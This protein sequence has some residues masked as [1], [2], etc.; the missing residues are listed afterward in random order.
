[1]KNDD[2]RQKIEQGGR[3]LVESK[4]DWQAV[5]SKLCKVFEAAVRN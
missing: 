5:G 3:E 2:A 1:M 4:Y